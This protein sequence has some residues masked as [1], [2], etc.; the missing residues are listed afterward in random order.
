[1][2]AIALLLGCGG[3]REDSAAPQAT[4]LSSQAELGEL[5]FNDRSLSASGQQACAS[6]HVEDR[7]HAADN[8]LAAQL[9]G[10]NG[11][12]G[13]SWWTRH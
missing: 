12:H 4:T 11:D 10:P 13:P 1:V 5:I 6:C 9:G 3:G 2:C 7:G 8:G